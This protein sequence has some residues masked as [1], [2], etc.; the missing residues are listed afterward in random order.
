MKSGALMRRFFAW[1]GSGPVRRAAERQ[2]GIREGEAAAGD[3]A[4]GADG[5]ERAGVRAQRGALYA[6]H[7]AYGH[8]ADYNLAAPSEQGR[9]AVQQRR[10]A[11]QAKD[12]PGYLLR[13]L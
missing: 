5:D 8:D 1:P 6:V 3:V 7:E 13:G 12:A 4:H 10:A 9:P 11:A 2:V